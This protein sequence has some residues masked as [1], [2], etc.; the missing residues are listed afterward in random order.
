MGT[1]QVLGFRLPRLTAGAVATRMWGFEVGVVSA[2]GLRSPVVPFAIFLFGA[3]F[4]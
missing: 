2:A 1:S 3:R 4:S